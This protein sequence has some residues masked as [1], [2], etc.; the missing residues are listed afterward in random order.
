[1]QVREASRWFSD[2][3]DM[4][5]VYILPMTKMK[6]SNPRNTWHEF[7]YVLENSFC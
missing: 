3:R 4:K 5:I 6:S 7:I 2:F 1:M